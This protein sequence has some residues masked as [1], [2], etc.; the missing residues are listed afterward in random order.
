MIF[1]KKTTTKASQ[2]IANAGFVTHEPGFKAVEP[3]VG[4][5]DHD[6]TTVAF[7]VEEGVVVG[8]PVGGAAVAG[9][10]G[11]AV[12][13]GAFLAKGLGVEGLVRV[14]E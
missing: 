1:R 2:P 7:G 4:V 10:V 13:P 9:D 3:G 12:A 5:F 11:F 14:Q 8:L 6:A